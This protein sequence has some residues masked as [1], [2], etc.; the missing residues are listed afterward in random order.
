MYSAI[1]RIGTIGSEHFNTRNVQKRKTTFDGTRTRLDGQTTISYQNCH[2]VFIK[3]TSTVR[4]LLN[5]AF[6][7]H[8]T[9]MVVVIRITAD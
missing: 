8:G 3:V 4:V 5:V 2:I 9:D 7:I 6:H 1:I